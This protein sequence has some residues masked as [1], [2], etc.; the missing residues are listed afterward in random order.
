MSSYTTEENVSPSTSNHEL[1]LDTQEM[2]CA[3]MHM[4]IHVLEC[5]HTHTVHTDN[6]KNKLKVERCLA[7]DRV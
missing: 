6:N 5:T 7:A 2:I 4:Y 3:C 1:A